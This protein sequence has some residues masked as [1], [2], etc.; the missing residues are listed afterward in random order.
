MQV[1]T[2][3]EENY[4]KTIYAIQYG[5][6]KGEVSVNEIAEKMENR[7]AT[8]TDMLRKLSDKEFQMSKYLAYFGSGVPKSPNSIMKSGFSFFMASIKVVMRY[9]ESCI[10]GK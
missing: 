9:S 3:T 1:L 8:V 2:F 7:P 6:D 5:L 10:V 4:L